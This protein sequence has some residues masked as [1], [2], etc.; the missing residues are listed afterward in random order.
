MMNDTSR[1]PNRLFLNR[2]YMVGP[3]DR[4][5]GRGKQWREELTPFLQSKGMLVLN[6]CEKQLL[7][8]E[9]LETEEILKKRHEAKLNGDFDYVVSKSR[10]RDID[11]R[12]VDEANFLI[13]NLDLDQSPC[14]TWEE[15]FSGNRQKKPAI[16]MC[17]QGLHKIPD[18]LFWVFK[19]VYKD[20]FVDNWD[21]VKKY[22][23]Y[24]D[25]SPTIRD[26]DR[27]KFIDYK[28]LYG[29]MVYQ[30]CNL[31]SDVFKD[32]QIPINDNGY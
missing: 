31:P 24:I 16:I 23:T 8:E 4:A 7:N 20:M 21:K 11:L 9:D 6:P 5:I 15:V 26:W 28:S 10:I 18:W 29:D 1:Q 13:C 19:E 17:P 3:M 14:G 12:L 32:I 22:I 2:V 30:R 27:W 25:S